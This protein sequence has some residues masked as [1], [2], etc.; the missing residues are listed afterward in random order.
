M[1]GGAEKAEVIFMN[2]IWLSPDMIS[3][4]EFLNLLKGRNVHLAAS[5]SHL[6]AGIYICDDVPILA[7]CI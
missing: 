6:A 4:Q 7:T 2:D 5:K 1:Y 3:W